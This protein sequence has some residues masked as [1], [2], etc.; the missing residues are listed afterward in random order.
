LPTIASLLVVGFLGAPGRAP[1]QRVGLFFDDQASVCSAQI[2]T[3]DPNCLHAYIFVFP[4]PNFVLGGAV[5]KLQLPVNIEVCAQDPVT[6]PRDLVF[7]DRG[8][9]ETGLV[10]QFSHCVTGGQPLLVAE[11]GLVDLNLDPTPRQNLSLHF[12]GAPLDTLVASDLPRLLVC[13]PINPDG[14]LGLI[15]AAGVDATLNCTQH[16]GCTTAL[17]LRTWTAVK[18]LYREP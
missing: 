12:V 3:F 9:L 18:S 4:P 16:C 1:A 6:Y 14:N 7:A 17:V 11:F 2:D 8:S 10:L 5:F 13:D 15:D